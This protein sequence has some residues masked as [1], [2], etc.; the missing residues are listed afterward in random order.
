MLA[1]LA[2]LLAHPHDTV[3]PLDLGTLSVREAREHAGRVVLV[4]LVAE[5]PPFT[6][7]GNAHT[8]YRPDRDGTV[9]RVVVAGPA[10]AHDLRVGQR[11]TVVGKIEVT[12]HPEVV[13]GGA[14]FPAYAELKVTGRLARG[15]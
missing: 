3:T 1:A 4:S 5:V 7:G 12:D 15:W 11:L 8:G 13:R 2:L 6:Q 10:E 9:R 14:R